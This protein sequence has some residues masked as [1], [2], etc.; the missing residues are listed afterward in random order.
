M[1][2]DSPF[3]LMFLFSF[4]SI[5]QK[6]EGAQIALSFLHM[7]HFTIDFF[8]SQNIHAV[9][10]RSSATLLLL[11]NVTYGRTSVKHPI[12]VKVSSLV[13]TFFNGMACVSYGINVKSILRLKKSSNAK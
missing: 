7:S 2:K 11:E 12:H 8:K 5:I 4:F 3:S 1:R 6:G 13:V 10:F 9:Y